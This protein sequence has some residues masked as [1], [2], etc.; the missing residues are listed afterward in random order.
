[1]LFDSPS[2]ISRT[3]S[4][5]VVLV[6]IILAVREDVALLVNTKGG[7]VSKQKKKFQC[8]SAEATIFTNA[9]IA[10]LKRFHVCVSSWK[11]ITFGGSPGLIE[12]A[13]ARPSVFKHFLFNEL[14]IPRRL[15]V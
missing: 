15:L 10:I 8:H 6:S 5:S 4:S 1:M 3:P 12:G 7:K 14:K 2:I 11:E 9:T 13:V